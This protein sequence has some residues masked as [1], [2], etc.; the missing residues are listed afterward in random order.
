MTPS[1]MASYDGKVRN[2]LSWSCGT[3]YGLYNLEYYHLCEE[4]ERFAGMVKPPLQNAIMPRF[5]KLEG[6]VVL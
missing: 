4:N 3:S 6:P 2:Y 1:P 5:G